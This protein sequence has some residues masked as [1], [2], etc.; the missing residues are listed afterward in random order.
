MSVTMFI[1]L[2][3]N[4]AQ[5]KMENSIIDMINAVD[6]TTTLLYNKLYFT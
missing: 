4:Q 3:I 2:K 5:Y 1:I 6:N